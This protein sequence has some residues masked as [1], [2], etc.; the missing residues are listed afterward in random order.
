MRERHVEGAVGRTLTMALDDLSYTKLAPGCHQ[1]SQITAYE[2]TCVL[3]SL[4]RVASI[5]DRPEG[6]ATIHRALWKIYR[7][8]VERVKING[9]DNGIEISK[10]GRGRHFPPP[11]AGPEK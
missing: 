8:V 3:V 6:T 2:G 4:D 11:D 9:N 10:V 7:I 1:Q 5:F